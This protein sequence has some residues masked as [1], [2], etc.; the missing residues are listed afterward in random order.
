V[1]K[2]ENHRCCLSVTIGAPLAVDRLGSVT[3]GAPVAGDCLVVMV[4]ASAYGSRTLGVIF[5]RSTVAKSNDRQ[6]DLANSE[7]SY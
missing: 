5:V 1:G 4:D 7:L 2:V 3:I 6:D